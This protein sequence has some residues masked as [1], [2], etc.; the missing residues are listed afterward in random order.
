MNFSLSL[1]AERLLSLSEIIKAG[2][3]IVFE[4]INAH[5]RVVAREQSLGKVHV[6][7]SGWM[8]SRIRR[9]RLLS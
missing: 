3:V 2:V 1:V 8:V 4:V 5:N 7:E 9:K 6:N